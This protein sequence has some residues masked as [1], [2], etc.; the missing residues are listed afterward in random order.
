MMR[1]LVIDGQSMDL[2]PDTDVTLEYVSD[3]TGDIGKISLSHSYTIRLPRTA[4]NSRIL[5]DP[6][7]PAHESSQARRFMAARFY[8]NGI[9]LIGPAKAY[10]LKTTSDAYEVALVW[11]GLQALEDLSQSDATIN[12]LPGLP[13]LEWVGPD[14]V[15]SYKLGGE[16]FFAPYE[17]G[18]GPVKYPAV[19]AATHP[20]MQVRSLLARILE[21]AG[22]PY[23]LTSAA[24]EELAGMV[25]L[26]APGH[27]P[28]AAME[29]ESGQTAG[30]VALRA[31]RYNGVPM[32]MLSIGQWTSG[33]DAPRALGTLPATAAG[34]QVGAV[35]ETGEDSSDHRLLVN[36]RAPVALEGAA[37]VIEG[38]EYG[39][40]LNVVTA[41]EQ[42]LLAYFRKD[43]D[44]AY[45]LSLD[46]ELSLSGWP[47]YSIGLKY[48]TATPVTA[49][50]SA[51]DSAL[52]MLTVNRVHDAI[53]IS[54]DNR[55]PLAG[56][57][58]DIGQWDF[59][60]ACMALCGLAP[61]I[62]GGRLTLCTY[63][64]RLEL[65]D[66]CDWTSKVDMT[67]SPEASYSL[68]GWA[69]R[70]RIA[71]EEDAPL[72]FDP[73]AVIVTEDETIKEDRELFKLPFAA[74]MQNTALHYKVTEDTDEDGDPVKVAEDEDIEPRIFKIA[75]GRMSFTDDLYGEGLA[76]RYAELQKIVR[77]PLALT[78]NVRLNELDLASLDP[79]RPVYLG[80]YGR[81][82]AVLKVQTSE[83]D[84]CKVELIQ[85]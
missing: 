2:A 71:Y 84:L 31:G 53:D 8:R 60:K 13:V 37:L 50:F 62:R 5:D 18:L 48:D 66:A 9:D 23:A 65:R 26:A 25:V 30:Y 38:L 46:E 1:E 17:S 83:S 74:S 67:D 69:Q 29:R 12:G 42:L 36:L 81:Y 64:E 33:W 52:P 77:R 34:P 47:Y 61:V 27:R 59:V 19:N 63:G 32:Q 57:L 55:F 20:C 10:L 16:A 35:L 82:Y 80:Q 14:G 45:C 78:V 49:A 85:L 40:D 79:A 56:N 7:A 41:R 39:E 6:G 15:P 68:S 54:H 11:N 24:E 44:G 72:S 70:N 43:A 22:V 4:R 76:A 75:D 3:I 51:Y 28:D 58:P 73:D 21:N